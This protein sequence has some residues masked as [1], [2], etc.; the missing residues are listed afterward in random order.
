MKNNHALLKRTTKVVVGI[1]EATKERIISQKKENVMRKKLCRIVE[2]NLAAQ[3]KGRKHEKFFYLES[4]DAYFSTSPDPSILYDI[5]NS[6]N[7]YKKEVSFSSTRVHFA[8]PITKFR[9]AGYSTSVNSLKKLFLEISDEFKDLLTIELEEDSD[10]GKRYI[11]F[12][13]KMNC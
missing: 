10:F 4:K 12:W 6:V 9:K 5:A 8:T 2:K 3:I 13:I 7:L 11:A 1:R